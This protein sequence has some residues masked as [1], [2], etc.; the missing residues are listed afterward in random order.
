MENES[1][2]KEIISIWEKYPEK[3]RGENLPL[4]YPFFNKGELL[5]IGCN[6]SLRKNSKE[7]FKFN[8]S[9][10]DNLL[11][12]EKQNQQNP[13]DQY[14]GKFV[15][16]ANSIGL[17]WN[18]IDLFYYRETNQN[19]FKEKILNN[20]KA[21]V[22]NFNDFN[23]FGKDQI[24][25]SINLINKINPKIILVA[26]AFSSSLIKTLLKERIKYSKEE[27]YHLLELNSK[28]IPI[29][30][31]SMISGQRAL[32]DHSFERLVWHM[33]ESLKKEGKN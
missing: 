33:K 13:K 8:L 16:I 29:F 23:D 22:K 14:F 24:K 4:V 3:I 10:I 11:K 2:N 31:S 18:H 30:F 1:I 32:D 19:K 27:G 28:E 7:D 25:F 5:F 12:F 20:P 21:K 9:K 15:K 17:T 6:P 26:N